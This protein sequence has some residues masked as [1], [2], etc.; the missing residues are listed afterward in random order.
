[1]VQRS[2]NA[3]LANGRIPLCHEEEEEEDVKGSHKQ[4]KRISQPACAH[5]SCSC[6][7]FRVI[8]EKGCL[9]IF[10]VFNHSG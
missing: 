4:G 2:W 9:A 10:R 3:S 7:D 1:M 8:V 6:W 5:T